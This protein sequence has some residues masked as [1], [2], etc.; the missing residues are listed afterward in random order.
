MAA[1][2]I[3]SGLLFV[4]VRIYANGSSMVLSN[5]LLDTGSAA[6]AFP[7]DALEGIG[8]RLEPTDIIQEMIGIGGSEYVVEKRI[9]AIEVGDLKSGEITVQLGKLGYIAAVNGILGL[10]FLLQT[11]AVIDLNTLEI[12]KG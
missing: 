5:V 3:I 2:S 7:T 12:R 8:V 11:G 6:C 9:T 1:I 4:S 10:D